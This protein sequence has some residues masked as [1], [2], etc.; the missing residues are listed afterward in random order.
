VLS[1]IYGHK[2]DEI[3]SEWRKLHNEDVY[4]LYSSPN[5]IKL[6]ATNTAETCDTHGKTRNVYRILIRNFNGRDHSRGRCR[7]EDNIRVYLTRNRFQDV[8]RIQLA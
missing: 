3:T 8:G 1:K 7:W 6:R 4:N 2:A 5:M